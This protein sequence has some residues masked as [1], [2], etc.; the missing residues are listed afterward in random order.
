MTPAETECR[1]ILARNTVKSR[2][3]TQAESPE[4]LVP[5][6]LGFLAFEDEQ[7]NPAQDGDG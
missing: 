3:K 7:S 5:G 6:Y 4:Y 1:G 2:K